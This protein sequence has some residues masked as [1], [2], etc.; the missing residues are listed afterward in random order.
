MHHVKGEYIDDVKVVVDG[1]TRTLHVWRNPETGKV[2]AI[3]N[4]DVG[5]HRNYAND[6]Y[7]HGTAVVF[8]DTFTGLPK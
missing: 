1:E 2:F 8:D 4:L 6:P 3:D 7:E 5:V